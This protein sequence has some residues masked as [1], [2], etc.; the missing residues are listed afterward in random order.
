MIRVHR[1]EKHGVSKT[2]GTG[3]RGAYWYCRPCLLLRLAVRR[4]QGAPEMARADLSHSRENLRNYLQ[5]ESPDH[6]FSGLLT[7]LHRRTDFFS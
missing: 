4:G 5:S 6:V 2:M 1:C 7:L 3:T